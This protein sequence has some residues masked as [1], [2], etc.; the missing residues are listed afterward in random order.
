MLKYYLENKE[1]SWGHKFK[2]AV[3]LGPQIDED[4]ITLVNV[5]L[6]EALVH[7]A[8]IT[9]K[10]AFATVPPNHIWSGKLSFM[11]ALT[12]IGICTAIVE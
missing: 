12:Y 8:S 7:F 3:M 5:S 6:Y 10:I 2:Q 1:E 9:W 4:N 11:I